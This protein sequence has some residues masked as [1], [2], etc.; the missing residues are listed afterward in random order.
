MTPI[1]IELCTDKVRPFMHYEEGLEEHDKYK[2]HNI[3]TLFFKIVT[4][5][6]ELKLFTSL[7]ILLSL[8]QEVK[9]TIK[10]KEFLK[11]KLSG[12]TIR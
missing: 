5:F 12:H 2:F 7:F 1:F 3:I 9:T 4:Y 6:T 11:M 8:K 10:K